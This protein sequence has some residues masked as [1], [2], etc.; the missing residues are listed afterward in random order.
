MRQHNWCMGLVALVE[1][2]VDGW[3]REQGKGERQ[4]LWWMGLGVENVQQHLWWMGQQ[5]WGRWLVRKGG[6]GV[7]SASLV[8]AD[9]YWRQRVAGWDS[10]GGD[11]VGVRYL[12][13]TR[14]SLRRQSETTRNGF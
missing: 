4:H 9:Q 7:C 14:P 10:V 5:H 8:D 12:R 13:L 1:E 6:W 3:G 2:V 11:S